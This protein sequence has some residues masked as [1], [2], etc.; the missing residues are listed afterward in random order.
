M[1]VSRPIG[2]FTWFNIKLSG[3]FAEKI[4]NTLATQNATKAME[5]NKTIIPPINFVKT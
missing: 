2:V 1:G 4:M 3:M 5:L